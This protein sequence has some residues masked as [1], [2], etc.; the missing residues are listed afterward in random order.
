[1]QPRLLALILALSLAA[2]AGYDGPRTA[3]LEGNVD[4][5]VPIQTNDEFYTG[6]VFDQDIFNMA[7]R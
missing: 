7:G 3:A 1:M 6:G 2:C 4:D 5:S